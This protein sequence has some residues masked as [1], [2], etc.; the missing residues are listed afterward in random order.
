MAG[1]DL[2]VIFDGKSRPPTALLHRLLPGDLDL[3]A[4]ATG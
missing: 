3:A 4:T 1:E 2:G